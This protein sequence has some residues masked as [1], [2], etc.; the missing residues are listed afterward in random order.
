[1]DPACPCAEQKA[2][3]AVAIAV[4]ALA[5]ILAA[6]YLAG[7]LGVRGAKD[8]F[9]TQRARDI[10]SSSREVFDRTSGG[11]SYS[12]YKAAVPGAE[13]VL[14]SDTRALWRSGALSPERVQGT[15]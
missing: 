12:Q 13:A 15:M 4:V 14:Y 8:R 3:S 10:Y 9:V 5:A 6:F 7:R 11:A 1:M 2:I